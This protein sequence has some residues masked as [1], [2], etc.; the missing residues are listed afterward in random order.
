MSR[1]LV[2]ALS[3]GIGGAKLALGLSRILQ[4]DD[5]LVVANVGDDFEHLGLHI[6]PDS[7][8]LMYTLA[9]L[10]NAK[11][12]WGRQDETWSF[13]ETLSALG[14]EDWFRL[15]D[16]DLAVHMERTRRL[17][18]GE[19]L[20][21]VTS[22]LLPPPRRR[23]PRASGDGRSIAHA[24]ADGRGVARLPGLFRAPS[25][26]ANCAR[27]CLRWR[28]KCAPSRGPS[29]GAER[30]TA[31]RRDH[32]PVQSLHQRRAHSRR[33]GD[34]PGFV[35]LRGA[36]HCGFA[37]HWRTRGQGSDRQN[38]DGA[39]HDSERRRGRS[40]LRRFARWLCDGCRGCGR[41]GAA[42]RRR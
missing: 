28:R 22:R 30:R 11:L 18:Q 39:W 15:G 3:G 6:S 26:P 19:S 4:P 42:S 32:L 9:G 33:A 14:G 10:D 38:D 25:M 27:A 13:M 34:T 2:V 29:G 31:A 1:D 8:T 5:L 41:G 20:S 35:R 7:D 36:R 24:I 17:R 37:D 12:G 40:A 16:R 23:S 21:A